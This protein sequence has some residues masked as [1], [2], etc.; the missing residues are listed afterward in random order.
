[1][2][3]AAIRRMVFRAT[4]ALAIVGMLVIAMMM[5][6]I[7]YDVIARFAFAAPTDFAYPLNSVGVLVATTLTIPY[8]YA[9][10]Q[11]IAMDLVY[12]RLS[13]RLRMISDGA[14]TVATTLLGLV[15]AI[16]AYRSMAVAISGGLTS[17]GTFNIPLWIPDAVLLVTGVLLALVAVL[18]PPTGTDEGLAAVPGED[19]DTAGPA[20]SGA[21][22][23]EGAP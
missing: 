18:F 16:S 7:S 23:T 21:A 10:R 19:P 17:S 1:M 12:R 3:L 5:V 2:R 4:F 22:S 20:E 14:T 6:T 11:H 13:A 15:L 8:L 9:R